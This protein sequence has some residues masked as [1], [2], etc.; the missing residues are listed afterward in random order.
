MA[1]RAN[2]IP[3]LAELCDMLGLPRPDAATGSRGPDRFER[4]VVHNEADGSTSTRR[5]SSAALALP[6]SFPC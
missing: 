1:E 6:S 5:G 2:Y 4:G 3:F